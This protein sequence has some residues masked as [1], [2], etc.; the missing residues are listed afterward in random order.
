MGFPHDRGRNVRAKISF[1]GE[2]TS[3]LDTTLGIIRTVS[4]SELGRWQEA[5]TR[6]AGAE[7]RS[8]ATVAKVVVGEKRLRLLDGEEISYHWLIGADGSQSVVR[9][10]LGLSAPKEYLAAEYNIPDSPGENPSFQDL[11]I[12]F[13][14]RKLANGYFWVFPHQGYT[15]IGAGVP[16]KLIPPGF[17]KSYLKGKVQEMGIRLNGTPYE[18]FP[19][20]CSFVGF[21]FPREVYLAGDAAGMPSPLTGEG[22]Y[23]ALVSGE[24]VAR[25]ILSPEY[26]MWK[27][28]KWLR[29]RGIHAMVESLIRKRMAR[30][31]WLRLMPMLCRLGFTREWVTRFFLGGCR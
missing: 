25:K 7:V 11:I 9:R 14:S 31:V 29:A 10:A 5:I 8:E 24:E 12:S 4:R 3:F 2:P 1:R 15:S 19:I 26:P 20:E 6:E 13:D 16:R 18:A 22:I 17:L 21:A 23:A 30:S 28:R 27:C